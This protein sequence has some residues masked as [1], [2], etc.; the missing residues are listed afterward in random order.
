ME[1][2]LRNE[3]WKSSK[4][5]PDDM[6]SGLTDRYV[7]RHND[8]QFNKMEIERKDTEAK[9]KQPTENMDKVC[10]ERPT[11]STINKAFKHKRTLQANT[12]RKMS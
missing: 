5:Q 6:L 8:E 4:Q 3:F 11:L 9:V 2:Y 1:D 7:K 10:N 12:N